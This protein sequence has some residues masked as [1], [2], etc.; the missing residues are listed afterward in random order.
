MKLIGIDLDGT[1]EDS[2]DDMVAVA[3]RVRAALQLPAR[4]DAQ[5]R[6][7]VTAGMDQLY[8]AC[9]DDYLERDQERRY[10]QVRE[11]YEADYLANVA[12]QTR[13]YDGMAGALQ[14][15]AQLG[16]LVCVT[17]KPARISRHLLD[18]LGVGA[19]FSGV[20]GGDSGPHIKP[21]PSMLELAADS[22]GFERARGQVF[23]I[24]DSNADIQ[25]G[26]AYGARSVWCSWGYATSI[27]ESADLHAAAP[28][29]LPSLVAG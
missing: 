9:F 28:G 14:A 3:R 24:G 4:A 6:P 25:L 11:A 23:M 17:N 10:A 13:L 21:H 18:T 12:V 20:V 2:R 5:L 22:C 19:L 16:A 27:S 26:R 29:E 8:R 7:H 1:I 15:L